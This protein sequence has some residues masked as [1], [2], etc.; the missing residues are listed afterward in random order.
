MEIRNTMS[1]IK[2]SIIIYDWDDTIIPTTYIRTYKKLSKQYKDSL[3]YIQ[4]DVFNIVNQ[5]M[6]LHRIQYIVTNSQ[7]KWVAECL[8]RFFPKCSR[9]IMKYVKIIS[10]SDNYYYK[11]PDNPY[12]WK[13][14]AIKHIINKTRKQTDNNIDIISLGDA[15]NDRNIII[16]F[17]EEIPNIHVKHV[18]FMESP[19]PAM[20]SKELELFLSNLIF[21]HNLKTNVDFKLVI[22]T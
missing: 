8:R 12:E 13:R 4:R 16:K 7:G 10:A 1:D 22:T 14:R 19:S 20:L 3:K 21:L 11:Y 17:G 18:K 9:F 15:K 2:T 6:L 5:C